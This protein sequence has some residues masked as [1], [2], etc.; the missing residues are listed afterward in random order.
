MTSISRPQLQT[1]FYICRMN[2]QHKTHLL[3]GGNLGDRH[4][5]LAAARQLIGQHVGTLVKISSLYETQPWGVADQ[6]DF[7]NQALEVS[8]DLKPVELLQALLKIEGDIGRKREEKWTARTIDID[9]LFYDAKTLNTSE[10][11]LP[12]PHLHERN[13]ALVPMLEI[14]PNKLHPVFK[15]TIEE[16]YETCKDDLDVVMLDEE[17]EEVQPKTDRP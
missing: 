9:I 6:P 14:A 16:L 11:E 7:L 4:A 2:K 10:L 8:T 1:I 3:I 5:N 15:K 17:P 12:H 13:F